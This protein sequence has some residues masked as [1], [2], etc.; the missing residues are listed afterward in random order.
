MTENLCL[1]D[2]LAQPEEHVVSHFKVPLVYW[3]LMVIIKHYSQHTKGA[4]ECM[5]EFI[6]G[7]S[8]NSSRQMLLT[9]HCF[10]A[11]GF[12]LMQ[13]HTT[14]Q[15]AFVTL[16]MHFL[17]ASFPH[18]FVKE[19][20]RPKASA[21]SFMSVCHPV[22]R[23]QWPIA[24]NSVSLNIMAQV[25]LRTHCRDH[26]HVEVCGWGQGMGGLV[27]VVNGEKRWIKH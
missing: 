10:F 8:K 17:C 18:V 20:L 5:L 7:L 6:L 21:A 1:L 27:G 15:S 22:P 16:C 19:L 9:R 12:S 3:V 24:V 14:L 26:W 11:L 25:V 2:F 4:C 13:L 23:L